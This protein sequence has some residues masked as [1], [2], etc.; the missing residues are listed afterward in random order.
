MSKR[1]GKC[2]MGASVELKEITKHN[3]D[4]VLALKIS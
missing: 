4:E 1:K 3:I 2:E